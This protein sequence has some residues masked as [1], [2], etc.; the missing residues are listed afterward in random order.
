MRGIKILGT[1]CYLPDRAV[2]NEE[3]TKFLDTSDEWIVSR[4]GI[5]QR[6]ISQGEP[7]WY[8]AVQAAKG[9]MEKA[10]VEPKDIGLILVTSVTPDYYTPSMACVVQRELGCIGSMAID[11]N[12]ACAGY[13][14]GLDMARRYL[15]TSPEEEIKYALVVSTEQL[16]RNTDYEDRSNCIL[17]G[18]ASAACVIERS[19]LT[20][21]SYLGADG[22]GA[23]HLYARNIPPKSPFLPETPLAFDDGMEGGREHYFYMNGHEVYKFAVD[24][25][26]R[27]AREACARA[28]LTLDDIQWFVPH[29]AN[30]RIIQTAAQRMK[31]SLDR[32]CINIQ[33]YGCTSSATI[34]L[35]LHEAIEEG[36]IQR[37][38]K[39]C[40]VGFGAGL[41]YGAIVLEY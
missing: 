34:P 11:V 10:Q 41:V 24:A 29:Q 33:K 36:R 35:A 17:F 16:S 27:S 18:D 20:Y 3:F 15:C 40:L 19:D 23:K 38:Q 5:S 31:V 14:Y 12:C 21:A 30:I 26:P 1:G 32:F 6:H 4:T 39:I 9:A 28:G 22:S 13:V 2:K 37:G 8:M 25:L 7:C